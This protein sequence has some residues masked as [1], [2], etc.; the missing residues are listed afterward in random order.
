MAGQSFAI[1]GLTWTEVS[2][3]G[4]QVI[5]QALMESCVNILTFLLEQKQLCVTGPE[6][7]LRYFFGYLLCLGR[8][9]K[10]N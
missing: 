10:Q 9:L 5:G 7:L 2:V 3:L 1:F 4:S 6:F 8:G